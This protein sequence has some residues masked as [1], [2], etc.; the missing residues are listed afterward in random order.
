MK[1]IKA[2]QLFAVP[3]LLVLI[4]VR[5]LLNIVGLVAEAVVDI[6]EVLAV[7][8]FKPLEKACGSVTERIAKFQ[9]AAE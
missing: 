4:S 1:P 9:E 5:L 8:M 3:M 6:M 2:E 7:R